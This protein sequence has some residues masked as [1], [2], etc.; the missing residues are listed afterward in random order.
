MKAYEWGSTLSL[1]NWSSFQSL[2]CAAIVQRNMPAGCSTGG[3]ARRIEGDGGGV[4]NVE[5]L[6]GAGH[7]EAREIAA[8]LAGELAQPLAFGAED[9]AER[10]GE[11]DVAERR[12]SGR[13]EA[14]ELEAALAHGEHRLGE[15]AHH[16]EG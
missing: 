2:K 10:P 9:E 12:R 8:A 3:A 11:R 1:D 13:I 15:I 16:D 7:V 4:G 5:A 6:D 14:D